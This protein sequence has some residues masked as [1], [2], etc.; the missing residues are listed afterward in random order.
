MERLLQLV[1]EY[2]EARERERGPLIIIHSP[3]FPQ[4][5]PEEIERARRS[6]RF[7]ILHVHFGK[8]PNTEE[9]GHLR[10]TSVF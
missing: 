3:D 10:D 6:G 5:A 9:K 4:P 8:Q 2:L 1:R 7:P